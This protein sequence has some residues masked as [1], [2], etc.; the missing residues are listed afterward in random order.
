MINF[1][2]INTIKGFED[3]KNYYYCDSFGNIYSNSWYDMRLLKTQNN[4]NGYEKITL[5]TKDNKKKTVSV[6]RIICSAFILN[7]DNKPEVNHINHIRNDNRQ[8][9]LEWVTREENRDDIWKENA[10]KSKYKKV[11]LEKDGETLIFQ[12]SEECAKFLGVGRSAISTNINR[13]SKCREY[14][15]S[16]V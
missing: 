13:G 15:V 7:N 16:Y 14:E 10:K 12:N 4:A 3:I 11:I 9:N 6:H 5:R 8:D 1:I 2:K